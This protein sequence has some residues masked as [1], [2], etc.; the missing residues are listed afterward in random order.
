[1]GE[2]LEAA[3]DAAPRNE[4]PGKGMNEFV[5]FVITDLENG[6][7]KQLPNVT[8]EQI[9]TSRQVYRLFTGD[10]SA[11]V[12][13][14]VHFE[15]TEAELLRAQIARISSSTILCPNEYY[16]KPEEEDEDN[17]FAI[18]LN[19]EFA[20]NEEG[21]VAEDAWVHQ[22]GHLRLE[23]RLAKY[24]EP[25]KE[26]DD[27]EDGD[28]A[29]ADEEKEP[30]AEELEEEIAIL[31]D[32]SNDKCAEFNVGGDEDEETESSNCWYI[33][34][35]NKTLPYQVVTINNK[36]WS[37]AKTVYLSNSKQFVNIYIGNGMKY[38]STF[39]TPSPPSAIPS[40]FDE[41]KEVEVP[42]PDNE[43]EVITKTESIF[44]VQKEQMPPP[45]PPK[46]E[47]EDEDGD[48]EKDGDA[49]EE[50]EEDI[51]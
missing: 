25:E 45:P 20:P 40:Q 2:Y 44:A 22:R 27:D 33:R 36:L 3:E 14:R 6:E 34:Q 51:D 1:M 47:N 41:M 49:E 48:K 24:I 17:P 38:R 28:A 26:E 18:E 16:V 8:P 5:Y 4:D 39:Y 9:K 19:E 11:S 42:D 15:W 23:G 37:G 32:L 13:G 50:E 21:G 10:L 35:V 7:W 29:D 46:E 30:S 31:R 43:D 12:G